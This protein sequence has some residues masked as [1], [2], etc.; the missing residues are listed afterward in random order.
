MRGS[1]NE[2]GWACNLIITGKFLGFAYCFRLPPEV[3][4]G[5][6][7]GPSRVG[8]WHGHDPPTLAARVLDEV[9]AAT[10]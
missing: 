1:A 7:G 5:G 8:Q 4:Y 6:G 10:W 3:T 2:S 9:G